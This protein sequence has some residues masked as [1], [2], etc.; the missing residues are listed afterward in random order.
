MAEIAFNTLT[1]L[2]VLPTLMIVNILI[3][4]DM[5]SPACDATMVVSV[6]VVV[7]PSC[8]PGV[9]APPPT[10]T[11]LDAK[12]MAE[13]DEVRSISECVASVSSSILY[14]QGNALQDVGVQ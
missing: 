7:W 11:Q 10:S 4:R 12:S 13:V 1:V 6:A 9:K 5:P 8:D 3:C 14:A 2:L